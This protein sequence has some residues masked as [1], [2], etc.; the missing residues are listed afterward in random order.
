MLLLTS[1][2]I[3]LLFK[4]V[5]IGHLCL[6]FL[7]LDPSGSIYKKKL[8]KGGKEGNASSHSSNGSPYFYMSISDTLSGIPTVLPIFFG[9]EVRK[10]IVRHMGPNLPDFIPRSPERDVRLDPN[11]HHFPWRWV[12]FS[13]F[14][15]G[16]IFNE[17]S[18]GS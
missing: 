11:V 5:F 1:L 16:L 15:G 13:D 18:V 2:F 6:Y 4:K 7:L 9:F 8:S 10:K 14:V 12:F 3:F 17:S